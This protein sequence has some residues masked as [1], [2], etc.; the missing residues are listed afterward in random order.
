LDDRDC[1]IEHIGEECVETTN[2]QG[3]TSVVG[4]NVGRDG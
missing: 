4:K 2:D 1:A 3:S